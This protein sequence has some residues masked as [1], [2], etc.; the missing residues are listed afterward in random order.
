MASQ[1]KSCRPKTPGG[2][3]LMPESPSLFLVSP[4]SHL[5]LISLPPHPLISSHISLCFSPHNYS[6]TFK[7]TVFNIHIDQCS[8]VLQA[9][10]MFDIFLFDICCVVHT[11]RS[12][13]INNL[14]KQNTHMWLLQ[15]QLSTQ[16]TE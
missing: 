12:L 11:S 10:K 8:C 2:K 6:V 3:A 16:N 4:Q 5:P 14:C 9:E 1:M 13:H 7:N 15:K